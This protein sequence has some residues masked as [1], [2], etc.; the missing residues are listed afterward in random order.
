MMKHYRTTLTLLGLFFAS[1]LALFGLEHAGILTERERERREVRVLPELI[2]V[3]ELSIRKIKIERGPERLVFERRGHGPGPLA[4]AR[5]DRRRRRAL[6]PG[7]P[8]PQSEGAAQITR[9]RH[10]RSSR[11]VV[12]ARSA[13]AIVTL[14]AAPDTTQSGSEQPLATL[15][16]GKAIR[17]NRYV[18]RTGASGVEVVDAKLLSAIDAPLAEWR[19]QNRDGRCLLSGRVVFGQAPEPVHQ[20]S[21]RQS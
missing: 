21:P 14:Y 10:D 11:P 18:R 19:E 16:V 9:R 15:A 1:L 6:A 13:G 3:P 4:I 5:A 7:N 12:W 20:R 8:G 17:G 2:D